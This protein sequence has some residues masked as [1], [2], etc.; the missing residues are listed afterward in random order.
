MVALSGASH[1]RLGSGAVRLSRPTAAIAF[2]SI[3][4]VVGSPVEH[5]NPP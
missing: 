2:H 4:G 3:P 1:D 5:M